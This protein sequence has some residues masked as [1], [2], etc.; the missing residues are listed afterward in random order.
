MVKNLL[1]ISSLLCTTAHAMIYLP[2]GITTAISKDYA[3]RKKII[4]A[5]DVH[6]VLAVKDTGAKIKTVIKHL[7]GIITSKITTGDMWNAIDRLKKQGISGQGYQEVFKKYGYSSLATMAEQAANAYR[8]RIGMA[9]LVREMKMVGH[10]QRF[11]SNIG[12]IFL[13]NLNSKFK[14]KYKNFVLDMI[15]A[16]KVV[17]CSQF[18]PNPL[19]KPLPKHLASQPKPHAPFFQ[20]FIDAWN[21]AGEKLIIFVDDKLE[22]IKAAVAQGFIGIH[23]SAKWD[24]ATFVKQLRSAYQSLGLYD[25]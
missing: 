7:P 6:D 16:G 1:F 10:T 13:R 19:P 14:N 18:G 22:N 15:K 3:K 2:K 21:A 8:P 20:E 24:D 9:T 4:I 23:V 25:K 17:D 12:D 5:Y 11:A